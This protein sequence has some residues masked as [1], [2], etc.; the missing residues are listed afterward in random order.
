MP[1]AA[2]ATLLSLFLTIYAH[3]SYSGQGLIKNSLMMKSSYL[4]TQK[5]KK[6]KQQAQ[7]CQKAQ[8]TVKEDNVCTCSVTSISIKPITNIIINQ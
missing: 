2:I 4:V 7:K 8:Y 1:R 5:K 3:Y 6:T